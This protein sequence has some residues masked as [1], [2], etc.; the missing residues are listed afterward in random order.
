[1][2]LRCGLAIA[3]IALPVG[4]KKPAAA[5][6]KASY[7][8]EDY[9]DAIRNG[10]AGIEVVRQFESLYPDAA[11]S[12]THYAEAFGRS[13]WNSRAGLHGRYTL[14]LQFDIEF[15][16]SRTNPE[17]S[18]D[19]TFYLNEIESI[20]KLPDGRSVIK[21]TGHSRNYGIDDWRALFEHHGEFESIGEPLIEDR[22]VPG[23]EDVWE[24]ASNKDDNKSLV[25]DPHQR[26][27]C[28]LAARFVS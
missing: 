14:T 21:Y 18:E 25:D 13:K 16:E 23:F 6:P 9:D 26:P 17:P 4:C 3:L 19:P 15:D 22:P 10:V 11:H 8:Q 7:T 20:E 12:I 5:I 1:M 27:C 24:S 28:V 2:N